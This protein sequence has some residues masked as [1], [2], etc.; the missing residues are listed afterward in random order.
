MLSKRHRLSLKKP[1]I[2][3]H[4]HVFQNNYFKIQIETNQN[5]THP[6]FATVISK[7]V[8]K[9][10]VKRNRLKRMINQAIKD[11]LNEIKQQLSIVIVAKKRATKLLSTR[12]VQNPLLSLFKKAD[13][14]KK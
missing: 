5:Q 1:I 3:N 8:S 7:K 9:K 12:E 13:I 11:N 6:L 14:I 2:F 10:A 4:K